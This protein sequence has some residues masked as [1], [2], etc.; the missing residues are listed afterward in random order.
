MSARIAVIPGDGIGVDV[1]EATLALVDRAITQ[2]GA[3]ALDREVIQAGAGYFTETGQD[4]EKNGE[5]RAG[6]LDAIFLGAIGLPAVRHADGTEIS[7]HLRLRDRCV[8]GM[9]SALV[10]SQWSLGVIY[11]T[12]LLRTLSRTIPGLNLLLYF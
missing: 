12:L 3:P 2:T 4:I 1:T 7:P 9:I 11:I 5:K 10:W 8:P 6:Q